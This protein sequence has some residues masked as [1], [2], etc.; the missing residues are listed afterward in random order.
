MPIHRPAAER[1]HRKECRSHLTTACPPPFLCLIQ[2]FVA[3]RCANWCQLISHILQFVHRKRSTSFLKLGINKCLVYWNS[4]ADS[5]ITQLTHRK[6]FNHHLHLFLY[7]FYIPLNIFICF[8]PC[9]VSFLG[10]PV[11]SIYYRCV[12]Y[13]IWVDAVSTRDL[14]INLRSLFLLSSC[15][16]FWILVPAYVDIFVW[17]QSK[18]DGSVPPP[19]TS[20][21]RTSLV[22]SAV[23][24]FTCRC[25]I[26]EAWSGY[27]WL[28]ELLISL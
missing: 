2:P 24:C 22:N 20:K 9:H 8:S 6:Q 11:H 17:V 10:P 12:G 21:L 5:P 19:H 7:K 28:W 15:C 1:D 14:I 27:T 18:F 13:K 25:S 3:L 16:Y 26:V 4:M 23:S